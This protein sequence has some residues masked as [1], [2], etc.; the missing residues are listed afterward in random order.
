MR[1]PTPLLAALVLLFAA[2]CSSGDSVLFDA[3]EAASFAPG[4]VT[5]FTREDSGELV[6]ST[7]LINVLLV[8]HVVRLVDGEFLALYPFDPHR[9]CPVAWRPDFEWE[10][11]TGWFRN[12]CHGEIYFIDGTRAFGPSP[13]DLDRFPVAV[14]DGRVIVTTSLDALILGALSSVPAEAGDDRPAQ[15]TEAAAGAGRD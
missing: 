12:P 7:A 10:G 9:G 11:R 4:S 1:V 6:P 15:P 13:R 8:F 5:T 14:V 2:A 3:G